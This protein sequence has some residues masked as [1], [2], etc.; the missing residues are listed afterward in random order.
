MRQQILSAWHTSIWKLFHGMYVTDN[1]L[2]GMQVNDSDFEWAWCGGAWWG[3]REGMKIRWGPHMWMGNW[4]VGWFGGCG[5]VR[6]SWAAPCGWVSRL[7]GSCW[8]GRVVEL[9]GASNN[10]WKP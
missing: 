6:A 8:V 9:A 4:L 3:L 2:N 1:F 7:L 5:M 10:Y